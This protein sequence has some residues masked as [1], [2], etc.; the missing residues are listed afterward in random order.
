[1][2]FALLKTRCAYDFPVGQSGQNHK[3]LHDVIY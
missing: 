1:M 3:N 2:A